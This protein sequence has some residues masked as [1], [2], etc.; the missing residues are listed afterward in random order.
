MMQ[1]SEATINKAFERHATRYGAE[2]MWSTPYHVECWARGYRAFVDGSVPDFKWL[3]RELNSRWQVFR[4][5]NWSPPS[6]MRALKLMKGL[7]SKLQRCRLT[8]IAAPSPADCAE[9]WTAVLRAAALKTNQD[10]PSLVAL[11]KFLHFW[12]PRL[13]VIADREVIWNWVFGHNWLW[14]Q[15]ESVKAELEPMKPPLVH[16]INTGGLSNY[17]A[18][19]VWAGRVLR[20]NPT[21][22]QHFADY[23]SRQCEVPEQLR[24]GEF[25]AAAIEWLL[26]GLVELPPKGVALEDGR[27]R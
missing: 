7:P 22:V 16:G 26:L 13:F 9:L 19:L 10:G 24:L 15:V 20:S 14:A 18:L 8:E 2:R 25:E 21:V 17:V 5:R 3:Y 11:S 1:L 27:G 4:S 12:N 6:A 23:V